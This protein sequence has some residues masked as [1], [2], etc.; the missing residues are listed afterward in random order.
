MFILTDI[1]SLSFL[2]KY[3]NYFVTFGI[4][5]LILLLGFIIFRIANEKMTEVGF[6]EYTLS[7]RNISF[8]QPLLMIGLGVAVPRYVSIYPQRNSFLP[9]SLFLM[10]IVSILFVIVL[11][12]GSTVFSHLFFGNEKYHSYILPMA[13][14]LVGYGFHA[15]LYGF[16]RGKKEVYFSNLIQLLNIGILPVLILFY[17]QDVKLLLYINSIFL[18][19]NCL[20][21]I[22]L[23]FVKH[24]IRIEI[25]SCK[26]DSILMLK[27]GLPRVLGDF[28]L[29]ALLTFPTYI[30]LSLQK[31]VLIGGDVAYSI[32]LFNLVGAAFGPLS[33]VLLP[34]IASFLAEKRIDLIKKRF[35]VFVVISLFLT[36]IGY[37]LFYFF[38]DFVLNLLLG[39]NHRSEI[40]EI[41]KVVLL[42][43]FGY[44]LYIV[45]RSFL[46]AIHVKAKNAT[47]LIIA[48]SVYIGLILY[49]YSNEVSIQS[50]LY[51]FVISVNLLGLLTFIKT[52]NTL[53]EIK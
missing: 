20:V 42:G 2:T 6:S 33:L 21:F 25:K 53:K 19:F 10:S 17:T 22:L 47:N 48:L 13:L 32:T 38:H 4:E 29:L 26:E 34:E 5:F 28:A 30:V 14:L 31:N 46:D 39:S 12:L 45:L 3:K 8:L 7:R 9:A 35:Y 16:L 1:F 27:Y 18:M 24:K 11:T 43:S 23:I 41:A 37:A 15:I 51:Y 36:M 44:V 40:F 50:Y 52:Y 49:G